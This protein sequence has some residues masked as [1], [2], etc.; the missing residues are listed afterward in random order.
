MHSKS[1]AQRLEAG[2]PESEEVEVDQGPGPVT[3][4]LFA[5]SELYQVGELPLIDCA[6]DA[7]QS[8]VRPVLS[9]FSPTEQAARM[10]QH[11]YKDQEDED[12][13]LREDRDKIAEYT[14]QALLRIN[15]KAAAATSGELMQVLV[16]LEDEDFDFERLRVARS[17]R[18][19][20]ARL[21]RTAQAEAARAKFKD[22]V[23]ERRAQLAAKNRGITQAIEKLG[24]TVVARRTSANI[25]EVSVPVGRAGQLLAEPEVVGLEVDEASAEPAVD[26]NGRRVALGLPSGGAALY[27]N[28]EGF[29]GSTQGSGS[30]HVGVIEVEDD[31]DGDPNRLNTNHPVF[32][33]EFGNSRIVD[34]E[35][36]KL[37]GLERKCKD[38]ATGTAASHGTTVAGVLLGD[39][40]AGQDPTVTSSTERVQRSGIA[41]QA[42]MTYYLVSRQETYANIATAVEAAT[43]DDEIDIITMSIGDSS[44]RWCTN[45]DYSGVRSAI[46]SA[47]NAGVLMVVGAGNDGSGDCTYNS[48]STI[49][50]TIAVGATDDVTSLLGLATV[51]VA[52]YSSRGSFETTLA[53]GRTVNTRIGDFAVNGTMNWWPSSGS[54]Y[55]SGDYSG[56]SFAAP[57][58]AGAA[59]LLKSWLWNHNLDDDYGSIPYALRALL[60]VMGDGAAGGS[61]GNAYT[62]SVDSTAGFGHLRFADLSQELGSGAWGF[63]GGSPLVMTEGQVVQWP[64]GSTAAEG[65]NVN[66]WKFAA[67]IDYDNYG[68]GP[69]VSFELVDRC[70]AGGGEQVIRTASRAPLKA[71]L[72]MRAGDMD[73]AFRGRCLWI[74]AT[75][76]HLPDSTVKIWAADYYYTNSRLEHDM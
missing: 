55:S 57:Q 21:G 44:D 51:G 63:G 9:N 22:I 48:Y 13:R 8:A 72:R 19:T 49:P 25:V 46:R 71:R 17:E 60:S 14:E 5:D 62:G 26:G 56:T 30:V 24:G 53:G 6:S 73:G 12:R 58:V 29:V 64:V 31:D 27:G 67:L 3:A 4:P 39:L 70:P 75:A 59:V 16:H 37:R 1:S 7:C 28:S 40:T 66:G 35:M 2:E 54:S 52:D 61:G 47:E 69:D 32:K 10:A 43:Y 34:T 74:R 38:S 20:A 68:D 11:A 15:Q 18:S 33:D 50:D 76:E 45:S 36:C 41:R 23:A 65:S 42:E